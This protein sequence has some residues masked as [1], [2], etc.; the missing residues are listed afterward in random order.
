MWRTL[1]EQFWRRPRMRTT[2]TSPPISAPRVAPSEG[3]EEEQ[4]GRPHPAFCHLFVVFDGESGRA[5]PEE[6]C[7]QHTS[8]AWVALLLRHHTVPKAM[9]AL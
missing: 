8:H 1:T 7:K 9:P 6:A 2:T 4:L 3:Q 5:P